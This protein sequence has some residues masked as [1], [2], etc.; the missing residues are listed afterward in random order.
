MRN[1]LYPPKAPLPDG[2]T[3]DMEFIPKTGNSSR[4]I[5]ADDVFGRIEK[6]LPD[7]ND[8]D[9]EKQRALKTLTGFLFSKPL[10]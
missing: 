5:T 9:E 4:C 10:F 6:S 8:Y 3:V 1:P 7:Y 2:S